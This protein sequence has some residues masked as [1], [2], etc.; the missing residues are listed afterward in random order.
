MN[1][2][3]LAMIVQQALQQVRE[4]IPKAICDLDKIDHEFHQLDRRLNSIDL[5][6]LVLYHLSINQS[7]SVLL[8]SIIVN[9][10]SFCDC[11]IVNKISL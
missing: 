2:I 9:F 4:T 7:S 11:K 3:H 10:S 5:V 8:L 1:K 6:Q